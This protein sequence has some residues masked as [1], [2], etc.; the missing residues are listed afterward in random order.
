MRI[1]LVA[2]VLAVGAC[3]SQ[4]IPTRDG[5]Y[6]AMIGGTLESCRDADG[7]WDYSDFYCNSYL[8]DE[9]NS[10]GSATFAKL[11]HGE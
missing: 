4:Q 7:F 1:L 2:L 3:A 10:G 11:S 8:L 6:V 9:N 5:G